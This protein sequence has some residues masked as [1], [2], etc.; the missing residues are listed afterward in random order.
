MLSSQNPGYFH[1]IRYDDL[2]A[3][4]PASF[5]FDSDNYDN[6]FN[7]GYLG[8]FILPVR[9][10]SAA[11]III[12]FP[13]GYNWSMC[14]ETINNMVHYNC[15]WQNSLLIINCTKLNL[16]DNSIGMYYNLTKR[17]VWDNS[18]GFLVSIE[19]KKVYE[20]NFC[21]VLINVNSASEY[22]SESAII[23]LEVSDMFWIVAI[24]I[25]ASSAVISIVIYYKVKK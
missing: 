25:G 22:S 5:I 14:A 13:C 7:K 4:D 8:N 23:V 19:I 11:F 24:I 9:N 1:S 3:N 6:I 12:T 10:K 15:T 17:I 20:N 18:T 2:Q 21:T 16:F